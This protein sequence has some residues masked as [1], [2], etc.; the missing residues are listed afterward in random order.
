VNVDPG[1]YVLEAH[2]RCW[3]QYGH[4]RHGDGTC[5]FHLVWPALKINAYPGLANLSLGP[6]RPSDPE[7]TDGFLDYYFGADVTDDAAADLIAFDDVV[8]REDTALVESVQRGV[9]SG[10]IEGGRLLLDSEHLLAGF[11]RAV[12]IALSE[13]SL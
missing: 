5:Q 2:D 9:R 11:Q 10:I 4:A 8:G 12:E 3:S 7:R 13:P 6:V 1:A